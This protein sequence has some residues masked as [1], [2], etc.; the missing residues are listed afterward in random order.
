[1]KAGM[2]MYKIMKK[3]SII[4]LALL[5]VSLLLTGCSNDST[6][7]ELFQIKGRVE[8][9]TLPA[10]MAVQDLRPRHPGQPD[11]REKLAI[12]SV[13]ENLF[14][15]PLEAVQIKAREYIVKFNQD[16]DRAYL[17]KEILKGKGQILNRLRDNIYKISL[18]DENRDIIKKLEENPLVSYIEPEYLV[19]IQ[20]IP[21]DPGYAKQWNLKLLNLETVWQ[22]WSGSKDTIVA[23]I[24]T[25]ILPGH[26]DLAGNII[27]GYDFIDDDN[28]PTD[29]NKEFSHGTHVA[30]IIGAMTNNQQGIAGINWQVSIMPIRVIGK[31]GTGDYSALIAGIYWAVDNG[32]NVIN[33]SLAGSMDT[34]ALREAIQYAVQHQVTVVAAAGNNGSSPILYP[35][36]YPEVISV[37][38]VGPTRERAYYSN[39]GPEL[40]LVAPGGDSSILT[41]EYNTILSTAGYMDNNTAVYQY[42]WAQGTSMAAPHVSASV[43]LLYSA[44]ITDPVEIQRLL[45]ETA[46]DL[47]S[48]GPDSFYGAGLL[49]IKRAL[50]YTGWYE[51]DTSIL[52]QAINKTSGEKKSVFVDPV[53]R[54]FTLTLARGPWTI[55]ASYENETGQYSGEIDILVPAD[56][57]IVIKI[58]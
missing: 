19:H 24:D 43:A 34:I 37:G 36:R 53:K 13:E 1:M 30:G 26:P 22:N 27:P 12:N 10:V 15:L 40:D 7:Q 48:P 39:Y 41:E 2:I 6:R 21:N 47:G 46:D 3:S 17:Q 14:T 44:G 4:I 45:R 18:D 49:N 42:T 20:H 23:V 28:D 52:V 9:S 55:K 57:E 50:A 16:I 32:A 5:S 51:D 33:L 11:Q 35:A 58:H 56:K 8:L 54:N 38:A 29:T 31:E 25:G